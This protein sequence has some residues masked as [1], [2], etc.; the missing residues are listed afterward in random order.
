MAPRIFKLFKARTGGKSNAGDLQSLSGRAASAFREDDY[1]AAIRLYDDI[2]QADPANAQA[3]FR[4]GN[5]HNGLA[6]WQLALD[7]Y[8]RA[9]RIDSSYANAFCNRGVMLQ[10]LGRQEEAL[11]S[12]DRAT[13]L[14]PQD[15]LAFYNRG[16]VLRDLRRFDAALDSYDR[17]IALRP[18]YAEAYINRGNILQELKRHDAAIASYDKAI[19]IRPDHAEAF[20][21]R[22]F[23]LVQLRQFEAA[24]ASYDRACDLDKAYEEAFQGRLYA[25]VNLGRFAPAIN[26]YNQ[27]LARDPDQ[28]YLAGMRLHAK[29][30][31]C[32]WSDFSSQLDQATRS[33]AD[34]KP[35]SPP[36]PLLSGVDLPALHRQTAELWV[37]DQCPQDHSLGPI[38][39]PT[40]GAKIRIGYFSADFR[41]HAVSSSAVELFERCD[42]SRFEITA[43]AFGPRVVDEMRVRLEKA[44]DRFVDVSDYSDLQVATLSRELGIDI[45]VDLGG[46]TEFCRTKIFAMRAAPV[47]INFLGFPGTMG[48]P[49]MD[50]LIADPV[51]VPANERRHYSERIVFMP[52]SYLPHDSNAKINDKPMLRQQLGLPEKRFVFCCFNK[53]YKITPPIFGVWM[54]VLSRTKGSVLWLSLDNEAAADNLRREAVHCGVDPARLIFAGRVDSL[55]DH[56]ARQRSAD[57]FL[58]TMPYNAHATGTDALWAG[59]PVLTLA[60]KSF[61][62]RV[63]ASLLMSAGLPELVVHTLLDYEDMAVR[64]A[65]EPHLLHDFRAK[66]ARNRLESALFDTRRF[67]KNLEKAFAL[68]S[69]RSMEGM[70]PEDI[71]VREE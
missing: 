63:S 68:I 11:V 47:Q 29:M 50:Y 67:V 66:L 32:D 62:S 5:A 33:L 53:K 3:Y 51:V 38:A 20:Q 19:E 65:H 4:R 71:S 10:H 31:I 43:F 59:L 40:R 6:R 13:Q 41:I 30:Q 46:F 21:N 12:Y 16:S 8:D 22:G 14:N 44:F 34:G 26:C 49:Y 9:I 28:R 58:D 15:F 56:L 27:I 17:S 64:L 55:A 37:R 42:K 61:A 7:D 70:P 18:D 57:L 52:H 25:L 24:L 69:E 1:E 54:R 48:A 23:S 60:G 2:L 35:V 45:A 39:R 36:F